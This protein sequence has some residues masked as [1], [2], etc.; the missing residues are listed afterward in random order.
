[1]PKKPSYQLF[2]KQTQ[3]LIYGYQIKAID[4]MLDFDYLVKREQPS[5]A[6]IIDPTGANGFHKAFLGEKEILIPIYTTIKEASKKHPNADVMINF[7]SLRSAYS[8]TVE[9][10]EN[11]N[12]NTIV[13]IAEG[14]PERKTRMLIAKAKEKNKWIIGPATVGGISAGQFKI[15]NTGGT[16]DNIISSKLYRSGSVGFVSKSG[17]L[18]NEMYNV[19]ARNADGIYEGIS[20][21]GDSYAGS[22]LVDHLIRF[23]KN[24]KIKFLVALGEVGGVGEYKIAQALKTKKIK[25]PL[26][27]WVTGTCAKEFSS[28]VQFG[29]AGAKS[30]SQKESADEK[31]KALKQAG[32]IV[33]KSFNDIGKEIQ[34]LY[35][36]LKHKGVI[37]NIKEEEK[38]PEIPMDYEAALKAK[39]VRKKTDMICSIS[40]DTGEEATYF[41]QPISKVAGNKKKGIGYLIGLLWFKKELPSFASDYIEMVLKIVADHGPCVSGAHNTIVTAR[42][43]KDLISSLVSGLLTIGPRF[44]GAITDGAYYF[45]D[46]F[47]R[48]LKPAEF[49]TEMKQKGKLIPG[50]GHKIKSKTNPDSRVEL[51]KK[52]AKKYFK[53]NDLLNYALEVEKLTLAKKDNLILN[54]DGCIGVTFIDMLKSMPNLFNEKEIEEIIKNDCLNGLF[55]LSRSIGLMGHYYDQKR[56]SQKLYRFP[57]NDVLYLNKGETN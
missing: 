6:A 8:S 17:G 4:R 1:M 15:A 47:N 48:G 22:T 19:I 27:A 31:N 20:V 40:C 3:A 52:Y 14:I 34:K 29:H 9:A 30:G 2:D 55:V 23:D 45:R 32:A 53:N 46:A 10:I 21:G 7:A 18:S 38:L 28:E 44:G 5:V 37:K 56:L 49:I 24:P 41:K 16:V 57:M 12:I 39:K 35:R 26:I 51:T 36:K 25:K 42:A 11:K 13:V 33:P 43:G 54:V 50:I